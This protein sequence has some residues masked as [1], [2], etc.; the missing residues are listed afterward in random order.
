MSDSEYQS[1]LNGVK[2]TKQFKGM[3]DAI[4]DV[5]CIQFT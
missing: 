3:I 1:S 4:G 2:L 5:D